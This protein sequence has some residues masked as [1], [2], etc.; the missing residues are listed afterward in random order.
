[1]TAPENEPNQNDK[2]ALEKR[3]KKVRSDSNWNGLTFEQCET[4]ERWLFEENRGY[5][6]TAERVNQE[7]GV[8]TSLWSVM[9]FFRQR[10]RL[11]QSLELLEAQVASDEMGVMRVKTEDLRATTMK[12]AAKSA[13]QLATEKPDKLE[14][15]L[16]VA[17]LLLESE[18]N[19]IRLRK[20]KL[21]ERYYDFEAN[22][23][24]AKE[25]E[26]VRAYLA[27]VGDNE[28][29][30]EA[31]KHKRVMGLL[32]GREKVNV[33]EAEEAKSEGEGSP[34]EGENTENDAED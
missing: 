25:L 7:F 3:L 23:I 22:T 24:C 18:Q 2:R 12:L 14:Q 31:E 20:V 19:E 11:R 21:E 9:R 27:A 32:F 15:L 29:L 33:Q 26:K 6:E 28:N 30:S 5:A 10:A 4:V 16:P 17:R 1:M 8:K 13:V 34:E